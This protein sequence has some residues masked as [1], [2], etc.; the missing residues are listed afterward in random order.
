MYPVNNQT[1][2]YDGHYLFKVNP[3]SSAEGYLWGFFR[4]GQKVW[5]EL[6]WN[7]DRPGTEY[8]IMIGT[9]AHSRFNS[10]DDVEVWVRGSIFGN[11]T[12]ASII[13]IHLR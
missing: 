8:G 7:W 9:E 4:D 5:E 10:G 6:V 1:L 2:N 13:R 11:W 3:V 12:Q